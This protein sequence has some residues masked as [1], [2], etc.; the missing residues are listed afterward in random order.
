MRD[1][2]VVLFALGW[3]ALTLAAMAALHALGSR[4]AGDGQSAAFAAAAMA[5]ALVGGLFVAAGWGA[6]P[7]LKF[8]QAVALTV[9]A[10]F[11]LPL[12]ACIPLMLGALQL[13]FTDAYFEAVSGLTTTGSTVISGLDGAPPSLLMWRAALQWVGGFGIIGL[14]IAILPFLRIGGM[15]LLRLEFTDKSDEKLIA[16]PGEL[17]AIIGAIYLGL[18]LACASLYAI[19]GMSGFDAIAHAFTTV[20]T[21]GFSTRDASM[22][23]FSPGVQWIAVAF[24]FTGAL[25]FLLYVRLLRPKR[26]RGAGSG[27]GEVGLLA[28]IIVTAAL[29]L[30]AYQAAQGTAFFEALRGA[31]FNVASIV[32]TTGFATADYQLWGPAAVG[33][34]FFLMFLGGCAGSTAGGFK[35]FRLEVMGK[36]IVQHLARTAQ[37]NAVIAMHH[38]GRRLT[39]ADIVSVAL[40][41]GMFVGAF[42]IGAVALSAMG[43]DFVTAVSASANAVANIGP[44]LGEII[45]PAGNFAPLPEE[46]KWL[47][48]FMMVLGRLEIMTVLLLFLPR[49]YDR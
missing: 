3:L 31:F 12:L 20:S 38:R 24:M 7:E 37:P 36:A 44:G 11:G 46:A 49:F 47:L 2:R 17:A 1:F 41:A 28:A 25:P 34:F 22:G 6:E 45:G 18:T 10:W 19:A 30:T 33:L 35:I 16:R 23:A 43:L 14:S 5:G 32:T 26:A 15:Q 21:A 4:A 40:F 8:R 9:G 27:F 29:V 13:S 39:D 48:S 42:A